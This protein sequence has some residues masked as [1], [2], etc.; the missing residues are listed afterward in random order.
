MDAFEVEDSL[1]NT[2][3]IH[4]IFNNNNNNNKNKNKNNN[5]I[6]S[7]FT[8]INSN[9]LI[10][11]APPELRLLSL[12]SFKASSQQSYK[13]IVPVPASAIPRNPIS[14]LIANPNSRLLAIC[15]SD[16]VSVISLPRSEEHSDTCTQIQC[17]TIPIGLDHHLGTIA[18]L[19]WH[20]WSHRASTLLIL[21][22]SGFLLEY[23]VSRDAANPTQILDLNSPNSLQL[24]PSTR[25]TT[26]ATSSQ[27]YEGHPS[28]ISS[29]QKV[30]L[31]SQRHSINP[32]GKNTHKKPDSKLSHSPGASKSLLNSSH[33][34]TYGSTDRASCTAVSICFGTGTAD[35]GP[36]TLYVV[37]LNGD[38]YAICPYLPKNA[39]VHH[40]IMN[41]RNNSFRYVDRKIVLFDRMSGCVASFRCLIE[42]HCYFS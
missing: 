26:S 5:T 31:N 8:I 28:I 21:Y 16:Q 12:T 37:M 40:H 25:L 10:L 24:T 4:P 19:L 30:S 27:L 23:D 13:L 42:T 22:S 7:S 6:K 18:K 20:P 33:S 38:L 2:L 34:G 9:Q 29:F 15:S 41:L 35:W 17:S 3:P 32:H 36:L 11:S 39:S 14:K 1:L